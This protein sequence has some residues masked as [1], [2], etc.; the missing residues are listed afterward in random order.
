VG[1]ASG[2]AITPFQ[3][4]NEKEPNSNI[5]NHYQ[6]ISFM[7]PYQKYSFE[8]GELGTFTKVH[9]D[10]FRNYDK[11]TTT[12]AEGMAIQTDRLGPLAPQLHSEHLEPD[13]HKL[14]GSV[15]RAL[16]AV[17][18]L[19]H[20]LLQVPHHLETQPRQPGVSDR[21][22]VVGYL[23]KSPPPASSALPPP[24]LHKHLVAFSEQLARRVLEVSSLPY[25]VL[26]EPVDCL[27]TP[28]RSKRSLA[29]PS[30]ELLLPLI[31]ALASR[32]ALVAGRQQEAACSAVVGQPKRHHS[33]VTLNNSNNP[34]R[35]PLVNNQPRHKV[36][37]VDLAISKNQEAYLGM[38]LL[39]RLR[40]EQGCL[41]IPNN[42]PQQ[43]DLVR[44]LLIHY[45][46]LN[47]PRPAE[48]LCLEILHRPA[49]E[50]EDYSGI[51][52]SEGILRKIS[53]LKVQA[54]LE[55]TISNNSRSLGDSSEPHPVAA[56]SGTIK[57]QMPVAYLE[58]HQTIKTNLLALFSGITTIITQA[59]LEI[60]SRT[61]CNHHK[62]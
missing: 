11:Q 40:Q 19:V 41:E 15:A 25:L 62:A 38:R 20:N 4:F 28:S 18:Y 26:Q 45:L 56:F 57:L 17:A 32:P 49:L 60:L 29:S 54:S 27:A 52:L 47:R 34:P 24:R 36:P 48:V 31:Q 39:L 43:Q 14:Q 8:V 33:L 22:P 61:H 51:M 12:K 30:A 53:N 1:E 46:A 2:T 23:A 59:L 21:R 44:Q 7:Q 50:E 3:A 42:R 35:I 37:L 9:A 13:S 10:F 6:A 55:T 5:T 16:R 58:P